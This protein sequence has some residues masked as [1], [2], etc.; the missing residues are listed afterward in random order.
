[1]DTLYFKFDIISNI[2]TCIIFIVHTSS[3]LLTEYST[4]I[5]TSA[6]HQ[7]PTASSIGNHADKVHV[8]PCVRPAKDHG[9]RLQG[10][11]HRDE[12]LQ[13]CAEIRA[14]RDQP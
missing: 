14:G 7:H 13:R 11:R 10:K 4:Q 5:R 1:M 6:V 12:V 9:L 8:I 2:F 3:V